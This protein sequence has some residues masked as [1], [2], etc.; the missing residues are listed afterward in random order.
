M[1]LR[2]E[3]GM[4]PS[5]DAK[6]LFYRLYLPRAGL[7]E[8]YLL[9]ILHGH[10]E[11]SGRYEKFATFLQNEEIGIGVFDFRGHGRS[12]GPRVYID[13]FEEYLRDISCFVDFLNS[14]HG[15][16]NNGIL[17]GHSLGGLA[18]VHWALRFPA[19]LKGLILSSPCLGLNIPRF[20]LG[21]NN[22]LNA[23][24]P[25]FLYQN[26]VYPPYLTHNP[27]EVEHYK[28]D[29]LIKRK[30]SV[31]LLSQMVSY[32]KNL[33]KLPRVNFPFPVFVLASGLEKVV[34]SKKTFQFFERLEAP[35]KEMKVFPNFYH[36][37]FNEL[38]QEQAFD[39]LKEAIRVIRNAAGQEESD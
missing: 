9:V 19:R 3:Q 39:A 22:F 33:E 20:F 6:K 18:A 34:D 1:P 29:P 15:M 8:K 13:S 38:G 30:I 35:A 24:M 36:E 12:Q 32:M 17:L 21:F 27:K 37:I 11:H 10:G 4:F 25:K 7:G 31:R 26:P 23:W 16:E 14:K 5:F 28:K 2:Y